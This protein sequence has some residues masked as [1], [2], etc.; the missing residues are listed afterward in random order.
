M[1]E[2]PCCGCLDHSPT[3]KSL[4]CSK[5][6]DAAWD[7]CTTRDSTCDRAVNFARDLCAKCCRNQRAS[8][9]VKSRHSAKCSSAN[10]AQT[11]DSG[12]PGTSAVFR[13]SEPRLLRR[14]STPAPHSQLCL[15]ALCI[16]ARAPGECGHTLTDTPLLWYLRSRAA[17]FSPRTPVKV[18]RFD[19][20][21]PSFRSSVPG[22]RSRD[23]H[24]DVQPTRCPESTGCW[25]R[26]GAA[27]RAPLASA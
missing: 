8:R 25:A 10:Q 7:G 24:A 23:F 21:P 26:A 6:Q 14:A 1:D 17:V 19:P 13:G 9:S 22:W 11:C 16:G 3:K 20:T 12:K 2:W 15:M 27:R 4:A 5:R 18:S